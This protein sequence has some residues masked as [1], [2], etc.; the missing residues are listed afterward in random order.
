MFAM[1]IAFAQ[2]PETKVTLGIKPGYFFSSK[3]KGVLV[4]DII[5]GNAAEKAGIQ[6]GDIITAFD[7]KP[8][9]TIFKYKD[10]LGQYKP[11]DKVKVTVQ[12]KEQTIVLDAQFQ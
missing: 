6:A 4:D 10:M 7:D 2:Q 12:R 5:E 11:G 1:N 3:G 9:T 8:I